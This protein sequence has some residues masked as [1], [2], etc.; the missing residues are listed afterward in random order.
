MLAIAPGELARRLT[1]DPDSFLLLDVREEDEREISAIEPSLHIPMGEVLGRLSEIPRG[2]EIVVYCHLGSRSEMIA[3]YLET[4]GFPRVRNLT[5]GIDA[6]STE[7][8]PAI[9]RYS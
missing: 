6:W 7:V 2:R 4:E 5:G 3:S 1:E 9:P 8:D